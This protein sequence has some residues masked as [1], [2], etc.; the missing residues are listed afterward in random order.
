MSLKALIFDVDGTL[1]DTERDGHR[2]AFNE[3]FRNAGLDWHWSVEVYGDLL[4]VTGGKE[5]IRHF[6]DNYQPEGAPTDPEEQDAFIRKLHQDKTKA[7]VNRMA[8]P[9]IAP[10]PGVSRLIQEARSD[11]IRLAIA[12][13]TT[14]ENVTSLLTHAFDKEAETWFEVIGAGDIVPA[15]KPAGDIYQYV[16]DEMDLKADEVMAVEDSY[17][18]L[19]SALAT[20]IKTIITI[21]GYTQV[22]DFEGA[23]V[24]FE[25]LGE[26][27]FPPAQISGPKITLNHDSVTMQQIHQLFD[28]GV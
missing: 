3:S 4:K 23:L 5:R 19:Q 9:G 10:R 6:I 11:G 26:P 16:L 12:T 24:V 7:Y 14:P 25:H 1:A 22:E 20:G 13:T 8:D 28:S 2:E 18:G 27:G 15:K 17:N 21:N